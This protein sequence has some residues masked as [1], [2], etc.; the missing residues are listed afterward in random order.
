MMVPNGWYGAYNNRLSRVMVQDYIAKYGGSASTINTDVA[1][2]YSVGEV[3]AYAVT[4]THTTNNAKIIRYL[5]S[6]VTL[7]TV[8]GPAQFTSLGENPQARVVHLPVAERPLP[9]GA[10]GRR[11]RLGQNHFPEAPVDRLSGQ[12]NGAE[13]SSLMYR[14][15]QMGYYLGGVASAL[16]AVGLPSA[17]LVQ[18]DKATSI[19]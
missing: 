14:P 18:P 10:A 7:N 3:A 4:A 12:M 16:V 11:A 1:E 17:N 5:H 9:P 6:D 19:N 13:M 15:P 8:Q 2:A